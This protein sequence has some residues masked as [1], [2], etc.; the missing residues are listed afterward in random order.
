[1]SLRVY[2]GEYLKGPTL[3]HFG[4]NWCSHNCQYCFANLNKPDRASGVNDIARIYKWYDT[5][6]S[7]MEFELMKAGHPVMMSNDSDPCSKTNWAVF[8]AVHD[9]SRALGFNMSFQTRGGMDEAEAR[10]VNQR[11]TMVYVSLTTDNEDIRKKYEPGAPSH[12]QRMAF[13]KRLKA[14][15]HHVVIGA[16]PLVP[17]WW[18]DLRGCFSELRD[19]GVAHIWHQP[20]HMS[21]LQVAAMTPAAKERNGELIAYAMK[22]VAPDGEE[23]LQAIDLFG[24]L[25]FNLLRGGVSHDLGFWDA[26][27]DLGFPFVP[28]LDAFVRDCAAVSPDKPLLVSLQQFDE[29]AS[30]G[31]TT[32][33]ALWKDFLVGFGRSMRNAGEK[34]QA[35]SQE[36]VNAVFWRIEDYP[37]ALRH[38]CFARA[39]YK[40]GYA[41]DENY[42]PLMAVSR[43]GFSEWEID[44]EQTVQ[45][46]HKLERKH[47]G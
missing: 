45:L 15:G 30:I 8:S 16:N 33:R 23:Y 24:S 21:H 4:G 31:S 37:T 27:F 5:G 9:A 38:S 17:A 11:P 18:N 26:Y 7:S 3:L 22:K 34:Q 41:A 2:T 1:M 6:S 35:Y 39:S 28:T 12:A 10:I 44:V 46:K 13:I 32:K 40:D 42:V 14:A 36:D 19:M 43:H 20:M 47:H 25:G 29:W